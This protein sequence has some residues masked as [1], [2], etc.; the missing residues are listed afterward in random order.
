PKPP[1]MDVGA[2]ASKAIADLTKALA[3]SPSTDLYYKRG[4]MYEIRS[5]VTIKK[6][7]YGVWETLAKPRNLWDQLTTPPTD[8]R[9]LATLGEFIA[10]P[11]FAAAVQDYTQA[12]RLNND[13]ALGKEIH[14]KFARLY[15]SRAKGLPLLLPSIK[16]AVNE[17]NPYNYS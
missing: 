3:N 11:D 9:E 5:N 16:K 14:A 7:R 13:A 6:M 2:I 8:D 12:L 4:E 17:S 1:E 10:N 15:L